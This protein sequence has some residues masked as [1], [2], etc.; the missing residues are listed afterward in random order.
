MAIVLAFHNQLSELICYDGHNS[1]PRRASKPALASSKF[2]TWVRARRRSRRGHR[3]RT[4][5]HRRGHRPRRDPYRRAGPCLDRRRTA[6]LDREHRRHH[7]GY[8]PDSVTA[9][10]PEEVVGP[11]CAELD[12]RFAVVTPEPRREVQAPAVGAAALAPGPGAPAGAAAS[13]DQSQGPGA[14]GSATA[15][16]R[17]RP[18]HA[19]AQPAE[20]EPPEPVAP[21]PVE[22]VE[23]EPPGP[24]QRAMVQ[25]VAG[26]R[27]G[28][29]QLAAAGRSSAAEPRRPAWALEQAPWE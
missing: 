4:G 8:A 13:R 15:A 7:R 18:G 14:P 16:A 2:A 28:V 10:G 1:L 17:R 11:A 9:P 25:V 26:R 21:E 19:P 27:R 5:H 23:P 22:P 24:R 20:S 12:S 29:P 3:P 6:R